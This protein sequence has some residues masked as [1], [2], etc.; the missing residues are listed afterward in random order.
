M[1]DKIAFHLGIDARMYGLRHAG[2]GR[3]IENLIQN[4][5]SL[6]RFSRL[7]LFVNPEIISTLNLPSFVNLV[8]VSVRHYSLAEQFSFLNIL[9]HHRVDLMHFPHFNTPLLYN[10][11]FLVTIHDILWHQVRGSKVTTLNPLVYYLKYLGYRLVVNHAVTASKAIIVPS[12]YVKQDL[13]K[14][15]PQL[16]ANKINIIYEGVTH[17]QKLQVPSAKFHEPYILYIGSAYPHK[18]IPIIFPVL[19]K[20]NLTLKIISSRSV[21]LDKLKIQAQNAGVEDQVE[22][23]GFV[24]DDKIQELFQ[25]ALVLVHP[26]LSEGFGLTG[27]EAMMAGCPVI[28]SNV[29][30]L[31]EIYGDAA[32]YFDPNNSA[33]LASQ[34]NQLISQPALRSNLITKGMA[35]AKTFS[36]SKMAEST[37][38]TYENCLSL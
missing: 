17:P 26:S 13:L 27:L 12:N 16:P 8:P 15:F 7:T 34:I 18:N 14:T 11:P 33:C 22:F 29:A 32:M 6:D 9:K 21:F 28:A 25:S 20:L 10:G 35:R 37:F 1:P 38:K 4:L 5:I 19:K 3:Y 30:S 36:W 2:I 24:S 31:P 23:L